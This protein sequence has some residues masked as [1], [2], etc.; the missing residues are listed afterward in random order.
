MMLRLTIPFT[1]KAA[2]VLIAQQPVFNNKLDKS[3][4]FR[5]YDF[6]TCY[7]ILLHR[8]IKFLHHQ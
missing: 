1:L 3:M 2:R 7:W 6:A 5:V 4:A 8:I